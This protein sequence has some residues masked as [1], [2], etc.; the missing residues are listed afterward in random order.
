MSIDRSMTAAFDRP[1]LKN[2]IEIKNEGEPLSRM[3]ISYQTSVTVARKIASTVKC[4]TETAQRGTGFSLDAPKSTCTHF[5]VDT[6]QMLLYNFTYEDDVV[7]DG[8]LCAGW[9]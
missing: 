8:P 7:D 9:M 2:L 6:L 5:D 1:T 4:G 3:S